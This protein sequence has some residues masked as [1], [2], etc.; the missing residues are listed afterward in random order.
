MS[1]I[2]RVIIRKLN[3]QI[4][5]IKN[6]FKLS[7]SSSLSLLDHNYKKRCSQEIKPELLLH[8]SQFSFTSN[9]TGY[10][11]VELMPH[12]FHV[13]DT[14]RQLL[15]PDNIY[16]IYKTQRKEFFPWPRAT[17]SSPLLWAGRRLRVISRCIQIGRQRWRPRWRRRRRGDV[18]LKL[19]Q[20]D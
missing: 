12:T 16:A 2:N 13:Y 6:L 11:S 17:G 9:P 10:A 5:D 7:S 4:H 20:L 15:T 19:N 3:K 8:Q 18:T 14:R 1:V